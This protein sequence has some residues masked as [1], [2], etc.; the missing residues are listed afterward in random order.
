MRIYL[1]GISEEPKSLHFTQADAW[2]P[3]AMLAV[4]ESPEAPEKPTAKLDVDIYKGEDLVVLK[5]RFSG[6]L[7]L[8]CSRCADPFSYA[9]K[10]DF[11]CLFT[12]DRTMT[13]KEGGASPSLWDDESRGD[14]DIEFL[15]KEHIE[16]ADVV[17][18]QIYLQLPLQPLC[19]EDCK[20]LCA[21]CGQNQNT[22]PCQCHR[23]RTGNLGLA[24]RKKGLDR[25]IDR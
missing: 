5:G 2:L 20:G 9:M 7:N 8:L 19:K 11:Q 1:S 14:V 3:Q 10:A 12:K 18:E 24:L 6:A 13:E 25:S 22:S 17:K 15:D 23:L 4:Q 16:L 21:T